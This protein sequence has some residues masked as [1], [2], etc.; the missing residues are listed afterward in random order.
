MT[1]RPGNLSEKKKRGPER[2]DQV[3]SG[4][5]RSGQVRSSLSGLDW[6]QVREK[7]NWVRKRGVREVRS[8]QIRS[9]QVRSGHV[10]VRSSLSG[11]AP[12]PRKKRRT[13]KKKKDPERS[14]Q[15]RS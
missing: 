14:D 9:G 4:Q 8:A 13:G 7:T 11:L 15:V 12:S 1:P 6:P 10:R 2:S 3:R 5:V